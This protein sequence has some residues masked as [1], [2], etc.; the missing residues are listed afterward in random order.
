ALQPNILQALSGHPFFMTRSQGF[1]AAQEL[2]G[3]QQ[4]INKSY[5]D[6]FYG[7]F[8]IAPTYIHSFQASRIAQFLFGQNPMTFSGSRRSDRQ[9]NDILADYFGLPT[10]YKSFACVTPTISTFIMDLNFYLGLDDLVQGLYVR[11]HAPVTFATWDLKFRE[12]V[13]D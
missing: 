5:M 6:R 9:P 7:A 10:D 3:W 4:L 12:S 13:K 1:N 2:C 11:L 8:S